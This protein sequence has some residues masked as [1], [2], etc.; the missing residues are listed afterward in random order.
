MADKKNAAEKALEKLAAEDPKPPLTPEIVEPSDETSLI[1]AEFGRAEIA[2]GNFV[3][4]IGLELPDNLTFKDWQL[5]A[6]GINT[7]SG[8]SMWIL[9]D[10]LNYGEDRYGQE[11]SQFVD[12]LEYAQI[13]QQE[14]LRIA[15]RFPKE[16]RHGGL[17]WS[18]H[19]TVAGL[20]TAEREVLLKESEINQWTREQLRDEMKAREGKEKSAPRERKAKPKRAVKKG[21]T[22]VQVMAFIE[23][24][25]EPELKEGV[26]AASAFFKAVDAIKDKI[27]EGD[28]GITQKQAG[29]FADTCQQAGVQIGKIEQM[30]R[31]I[32]AFEIREVE[33]EK[34]KKEKKKSAKAERDEHNKKA[35]DELKSTMKPENAPAKAPAPKK[36]TRKGAVA[37]PAGGAEATA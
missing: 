25:F 23:Q 30:A 34:P 17:P 27:Q 37:A 21:M 11:F 13:T 8:A 14:A 33:P 32:A 4:K 5:L 3:S 18:Y 6:D 15:R 29:A 9:G 16:T 20:A 31:R 26:K 12:K 28:K 1:V 19:Q 10:W 35:I 22:V 36:A 7:F 2:L 24:E